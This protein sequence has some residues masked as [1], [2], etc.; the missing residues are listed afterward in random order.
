MV[1]AWI[2]YP[3]YFFAYNS[4]S[5]SISTEFFFYLFFPFIIYKWH[6]TWRL[7]L[8]FS[9]FV[10]ILMLIASDILQSKTVGLFDD[11]FTR[12]GILY[13]SPI[14][15]I[16]EFIFGMFIAKIYLNNSNIINWGTCRATLYEFL[17]ILVVGASMYYLPLLGNWFNIE[18]GEL[19][20][21]YWL[22]FAGSMFA[23]GLLIYVIAIGRGWI[24]SFLSHP[25]LVLLGEIS[26]SLYMIHSTLIRYYQAN[27]IAFPHLSDLVSLT[28]FWI[29]LLLASYLMWALIEMPT[30]QLIL[31]KGRTKI[32]GTNIMRKSWS[33]H[34]NLNKKTGS[35]IIALSLL[36]YGIYFSMDHSAA[37]YLQ[38]KHIPITTD[39]LSFYST[40]GDLEIINLLI[41]AGVDI[42]AKTSVG[43]RALI[44]SSWAGKKD[45]VL[46]LLNAKA[47]INVASTSGLTALSA[48]INQNHES[49][50]L[51]LLAHDANPNVADLN[52][53]TL[54]IDAAWRGDLL[55]VK[56]LLASG[57]NL[58]YM[59]PDNKIT[60]LKAAISN[61]KMDIAQ[62]LKFLGASVN[63]Q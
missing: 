51:L 21:S 47:D 52:G 8:L 30:R 36:V 22:S 7:K 38:R 63:G 19:A 18:L 57:A 14:T 3:N 5:W 42:N 34:L 55:I 2:P 46:R 4:P 50:A 43:G 45:V 54:L 56:A 17:S 6:K 41:E 15:R 25:T 53:N 31:G 23:F 12:A 20:F 16:F 39:S 29:T 27:I 40:R 24:N 62:V 37:I 26:F 61:G 33:T 44:D 9:G 10:V 32:H 60:A 59:R 1:N 48:A 49:L 11:V 28:I 13:I 58:N 35:A